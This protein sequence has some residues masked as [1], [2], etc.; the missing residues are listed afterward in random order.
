MNSAKHHVPSYTS[1][2]VYFSLAGFFMAF[3]PEEL[4]RL[5]VIAKLLKIKGITLVLGI[6]SF[7]GAI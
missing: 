5:I 1:A 7:F 2:A 3:I 4:Q 6:V